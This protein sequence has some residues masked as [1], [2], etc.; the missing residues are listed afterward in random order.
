[1]RPRTPKKPIAWRIA[2]RLRRILVVRLRRTWAWL[3]ILVLGL[4]LLAGGAASAQVNTADLSGQVLD[5]QGLAVKGAKVTVRN[6]ADNQTR[7][8]ET[9]ETGIYRIVGLP[10]GRYEIT[11]EGGTGFA[12]LVNPEI[13]LTIGQSASFDAHLEIQKG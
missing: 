8:A 1:M 7:S 9:D 4:V 13:V 2:M 12:K 5:P 11:V 10:P 3:G 6:L